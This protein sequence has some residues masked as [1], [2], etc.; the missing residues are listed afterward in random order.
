MSAMKTEEGERALVLPSEGLSV[1]E[2]ARTLSVA[3]STVSAWVRDV[4]LTDAHRAA[5]LKRSAMYEGRAV[6]GRGCER[7]QRTRSPPRV[8]AGWRATSEGGIAEVRR[9]LHALL[10]GR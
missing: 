7:C 5:L 8:S 3:K 9:R 2:I 10:G 4:P 6:E 1:V